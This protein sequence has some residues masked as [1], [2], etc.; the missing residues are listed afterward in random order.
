MSARARL[1]GRFLDERLHTVGVVRIPDQ[2]TSTHKL[3]TTTLFV[4][5]PIPEVSERARKLLPHNG[6]RQACA[7]PY[8]G[9]EPGRRREEGADRMPPTISIWRTKVTKTGRTFAQIMH[10]LCSL[11]GEADQLT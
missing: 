8:F 5:F 2:L 11:R 9:D 10:N 7:P 3:I 6:V 1:A 4:R